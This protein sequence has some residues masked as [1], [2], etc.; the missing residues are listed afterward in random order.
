MS[1]TAA[2]VQ[3]LK[4]ELK[5]AG[6]TY[7]ALAVELGLAESS[8]KR[9]LARGD[10]PLARVDAICRVLKTDF[11]ELA[12][13]VAEAQAQR[14]MLTPEQEAAVVADPRLL[15]LAL[16]VLSQWSAAQITA[17]YRLSDAECVA[18]LAK[19]DA[20]GVIELRAGNRYR[21]RVAKTLRWQP[22]G[23]IMRFFRQRVAGDFFAGGFDGD[24]E[25]LMLVHGQVSPPMARV[26]NER[27]QRLAQDFALQH[28]AD[29]RLPAALKRPFTLLIGL[30]SWLFAGLRD[31]RRQPDGPVVA[32]APGDETAAG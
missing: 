16:C 7:A 29:Q 17:T 4:A 11:A 23:P 30:R 2:L 31:F 18:G 20:L 27:L 3:V 5:R 14:Q 10:M 24:D 21:L 13:Q 25:L 6:I 1:T 9:M 15:V 22:D 28:L 32:E 8:V 12:R 19:L 26:F